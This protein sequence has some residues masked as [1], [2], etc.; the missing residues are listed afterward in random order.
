MSKIIFSDLDGTLLC[1]DKSISPLN[2]AAIEQATTRGHSFVVAT[3]RPFE[4]AKLINDALGL[5]YDGCYIVSYNGAHVYDCYRKKVLF[6]KQ[7]KMQTLRELFER[8]D[9]AGIYIHTYQHGQI[10][11]KARTAEL[12]RYESRTNLPGFAT[13]DVFGFL[14]R[15]PNKAILI[16]LENHERLEQ[17]R[18]DNLEWAKGKCNF[19]FSC[20]EYLEVMPEGISKGTGISFLADYL[21]VD[22]SDTIAVGDE[23][24]DIEMIS[25]A[26][27]GIAM[28]NGI[29]AAKEVA[30]YVT[31]HNNNE[32]A[33][34]EIIEKFVLV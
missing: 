2:R 27:V 33:M 1:D 12:D 34:K 32:D 6:S 21:G 13:A 5:N 22:L 20:P 16:D 15:E 19:I 23:Q 11:T 8:A 4:S 14:T 18:Q 10:V 3:G 28:C 17:F 26:G 9:A 7:L 30:D 29:P 25:A 31:G 24:N